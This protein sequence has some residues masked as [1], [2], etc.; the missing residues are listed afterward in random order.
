MIQ[1]TSYDTG[2]I[3][4]IGGQSSLG[5]ADSGNIGPGP[6]YSI[7][8]EDMSTTDGIYLGSKFTIN[9]T[10]IASLAPS[11]YSHTDLETKGQRQETIQ[12]FALTDLK[13]NKE[14]KAYGQGKLEIT[15]YGGMPNQIVFSDA[16]LIS[17]NLSEQTPENP[18]I[19]YLEHSF[20]FEAH[21][22]ISNSTNSGW[23]L[24]KEEPKWK[25]VS[26][27]E[28][29]DLS[30]ND[31][32]DVFDGSDLDAGD[33][34]KTY[35]LS[36]TISAVGLRKFDSG[37]GLDETDGHAWRQAAGWVADRLVA[38]G[39]LDPDQAIS[40]DLVGNTDEISAAFHPFYMNKNSTTNIVDL[41]TKAYK[42]R[43]KTRI[44]NS[45]I[46]SG[47]YS[48]T[49]TWVLSLDGIKAFHEVNVNIEASNDADV[50]TV[51]VDGN[52]VGLTEKDIGDHIDDKYTNALAEYN[53]FFTGASNAL[54]SKIGAVAQSIY[55]EFSFSGYTLGDLQTSAISHQETHDKTNGSISWS[56]SFNDKN[57]STA[58]AISR[59]VEF[60]Y[61]N[62][63][64]VY[65]NYQI[66]SPNPIPVVQGGPYL[67]SPGTTPEKKIT[68]NVNLVMD[69]N[70]RT[71][72]PNGRNEYSLP[73]YANYYHAPVIT[74][75]TESWN[76]KTGEYNLTDEWTYV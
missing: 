7:N 68:V 2:Q 71:I 46:A 54:S 72:K 9:I 24:S 50:I 48:V 47:S 25:L 37:G 38:T 22:D 74:A 60:Q 59:S 45:D 12:G 36:H 51:T 11:D 67:Y 21:E 5:G 34:Y 14:S 18:G 57:I 61:T 76:P 52:V 20:T 10:G 29:W 70:N 41:K 56:T 63:N 64:G 35:T 23:S 19:Q 4:L 28:A 30:V 33:I 17:I 43:N 27:E 8:R 13:F 49:D 58:G 32:Q 31:G 73:A 53:K 1:F 69:F 6:R 65:R 75:S 26:S 66:Q 42:A 15:A 3:F 62:S 16:K 39:D 55:D 40:Q 44:I